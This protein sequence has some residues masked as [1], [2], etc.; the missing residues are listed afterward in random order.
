MTSFK[1]PDDLA[2]V[3]FVVVTRPGDTQDSARNRTL[4]ASNENRNAFIVSF[5]LIM[6]PSGN[7]SRRSDDIGSWRWM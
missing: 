2:L 1:G 6:D 5:E 4:K 7:K 3:V